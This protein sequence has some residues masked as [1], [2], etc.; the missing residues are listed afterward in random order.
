MIYVKYSIRASSN[1]IAHLPVNTF[2]MAI[3]V[4]PLD[5]IENNMDAIN[6]NGNAAKPNSTSTINVRISCILDDQPSSWNMANVIV[7]NIAVT[8]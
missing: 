4:N 7:M 1:F 5:G 2:M 3:R 6:V 8:M